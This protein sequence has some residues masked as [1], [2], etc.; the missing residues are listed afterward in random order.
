MD[1]LEIIR[2]KQTSETDKRRNKKYLRV[3]AKW[4]LNSPD[5]RI[6]VEIVAIKNDMVSVLPEVKEFKVAPKTVSLDMFLD[7]HSPTKRTIKLVD[8]DIVNDLECKEPNVKVEFHI[9]LGMLR[10]CP[11]LVAYR[12]TFK[13]EDTIYI[14]TV[15]GKQE[16]WLVTKDHN[17][18]VIR[19]R[20]T[21]HQAD[22]FADDWIVT[23]DWIVPRGE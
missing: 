23:D 22:M 10:K 1:N 18:S 21:P 17:S 11:D 13:P 8:A 4:K 7:T 6:R 12:A 9:M 5:L 3:G 15:D 14:E 19:R 16:L 2:V 20:Y